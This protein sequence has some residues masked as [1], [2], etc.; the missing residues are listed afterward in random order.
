MYAFASNH[1]APMDDKG[2]VVLPLGL[3]KGIKEEDRERVLEAGFMVRPSDKNEYL[4]MFPLDIYT[5]RAVDLES[6]Y[7]LDDTAGQAYLRFFHSR[8]ERVDVDRQYRFTI[9]EQSIKALGLEGELVLVGRR[10]MIEIWRRDR[11]IEWQQDNNE[12]RM[13]PASATK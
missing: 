13:P 2:R 10:R 3:R 8:S 7:A 6:R 12:F 5:E 4:E 9:P 11:W 1:P